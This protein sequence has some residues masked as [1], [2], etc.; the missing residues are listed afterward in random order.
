ME[1]DAERVGG[2][3][4]GDQQAA[5]VARVGA[6]LGGEAELRMI[7]AHADTYKKVEVRG[8]NAILRR[9]ADDLLKLLDGVE[10]EGLHAMVEI[11]LGDG[12]LSLHRVH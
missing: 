8:R 7:R 5:D 1:A 10:A 2:L 6:E 11:S 9:R 3:A 12:F 4:G